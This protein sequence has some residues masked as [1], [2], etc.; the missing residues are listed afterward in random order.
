M[1]DITYSDLHSGLFIE[2]SGSVKKVIN[3]AAINQS[4]K[5]ILSTTPGERIMLPSFGSKI[6]SVLF[7]QI[8]PLTAEF[9]QDEIENAINRWEDRIR[10]VRVEV[11]SNHD[12]NTYDVNIEYRII[13]TGEVGGLTG[14]IRNI[15]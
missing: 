4:I 6:K 2:A 14:K 1:A 8:D 13:A 10:V 9:I 11:E 5:T 12:S 3:E 15:G 7:E